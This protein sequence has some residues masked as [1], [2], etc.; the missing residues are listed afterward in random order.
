MTDAPCEPLRY[1]YD[2]IVMGASFRNKGELLELAGCDRLTI[3]PKF[4]K[5]LQECTDPVPTKLSVAGANADA[6]VGPKLDMDESMFRWMMCQDAM[7]TEKLAQGIR[8]FAA[9]LV[10]LEAV[11]QAKLDLA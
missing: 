1:G 4:L 7:A 8:G 5:V 6:S 11:L 2:T 9:D 3:A 10:K